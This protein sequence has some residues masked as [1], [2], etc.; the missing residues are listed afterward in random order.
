MTSLY[1]IIP[2]II[3]F[4]LFLPIVLEV[5][6]SYNILSN[7]GVISLFLFKKN[8]IHYIFEINGNTIALKS[9]DKTIEKKIELN[10]P[11]LEFY[12][13]FV[14]EVKEKLRL[15]FI[16]INYNI[17][18]DDAFLTSMVCGYINLIC[19]ILFSYIKNQKPT[20][21]VKLYDTPSF[22][23]KEGV[24]SVKMNL[25]ISLFDLVY[26]LLLSVILTIKFKKQIKNNNM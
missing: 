6:I 7:T 5:R 13:Y 23:K 22:N 8:I 18:V 15:R 11:E 10:S 4:L 2:A 12:K 20:A 19:N 26:S 1:L 9:E 24:V 3:I 16:E 21:S 25:S 14:S 17:G